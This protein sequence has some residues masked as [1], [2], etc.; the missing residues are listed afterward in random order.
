MVSRPSLIDTA[1][2]LNERGGRMLQLHSLTENIN[3]TAASGKP[4]GHLFAWLPEFEGDILHQRVNAGLKACAGAAV[5]AAT[6][7]P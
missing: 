6:P 7:K 1:V 2:L 5:S 4:T 3:T